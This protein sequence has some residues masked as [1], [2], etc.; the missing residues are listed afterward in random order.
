MVTVTCMESE[1][2]VRGEGQARALPDRAVLN[3]TVE[4]EGAD[5]DDAYR[6][7]SELAT[8]V[9]EV[10]GRYQVAIDRATTAALVVQPKTRWRKGETVRTGWRAS[11]SSVVDVVD[12]ARLGDL[13]SELAAAGAAIA[14]PW[15]QLDP[16]NPV[17]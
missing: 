14:G 8:G 15:W 6:S 3:V 5:H 9:D 12:L 13:V 17:H 7:A 2:I 10:L 4:S 16:T 1:I 11:R